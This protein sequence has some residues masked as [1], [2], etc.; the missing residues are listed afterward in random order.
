LLTP[1]V[2]AEAR[3]ILGGPHE[4]HRPVAGVV[5]VTV[6]APVLGVTGRH[7]QVDR[8]HQHRLGHDD[9][10]GEHWLGVDDRWRRA[11]TEHHLAVDSGTISPVI[12]TPTLTFC[13]RASGTAAT[14]ASA[15][16]NTKR[17]ALMT[18]LP[19]THTRRAL[20]QSPAAMTHRRW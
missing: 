1:A 5:L 16:G 3:L 17:I 4:I 8:L 7:V 15:D 19:A 13:A 2:H 9:R 18:L 14:S 20:C 12:V 11:V 10:R 6:L